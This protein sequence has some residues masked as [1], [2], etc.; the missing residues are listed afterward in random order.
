MTTA[1]AHRFIRLC[2]LLILICA[3]ALLLPWGRALR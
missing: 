3:A 2:A 1:S